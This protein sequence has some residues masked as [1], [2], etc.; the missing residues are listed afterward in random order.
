M[1]E[2][3]DAVSRSE[4]PNKVKTFFGHPF[5][6]TTIFLT[7]MWERFSYYSMRAILLYFLVDTVANN[8]LGLEESLGESLVQVYSASIFLIAVLGGLKPSRQV[9]QSKR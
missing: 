8:G 1:S 9:Q 7:E 2:H 3:L 4:Q 5:G 6:L